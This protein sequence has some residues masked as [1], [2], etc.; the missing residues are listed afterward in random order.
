VQLT[1]TPVD[2]LQDGAAARDL[3]GYLIYRRSGNNPWMRLT[4]EPVSQN[5]YQDLAVLNEVEYTYKVQARRRLGGDSLL[6]GDSPTRTAKPEKRTPPPPLLNLLAV[7]TSQGVELRWELSPAPDLAGY[8]VYRRASGQEKF[9]PVTPAL[10]K[11]PYLVDTQVTRGQTYHYYVT[12][13]D[14]SPRA[15]ESPP[16]EEAEVSY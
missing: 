3:A 4:P 1:W 16:S 2:K 11:K 14:N 9:T 5:H 7:P 12:A 10:L 15:N 6:S 13:V 8:R